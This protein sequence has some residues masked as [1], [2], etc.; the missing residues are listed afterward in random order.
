VAYIE[1]CVLY[2]LW[3][4]YMSKIHEQNTWARYMSKI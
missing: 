1:T 4:R 3:A 2:S